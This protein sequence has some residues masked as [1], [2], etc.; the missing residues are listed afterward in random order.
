M[1]R[2]VPRVLRA[3]PAILCLA[4]GWWAFA[5]AP[6]G[7]HLQF[8]V[9]DGNSMEPKL[10][11]GDVVALRRVHSARP[12]EVVAYR[13]DLLER[14]VLHR[15]VGMSDGRYLMQGDNNGWTDPERPTDAQL[16]GRR[17]FAVHGLGRLF[18]PL[19]HPTVAALLI[20]LLAFAAVGSNGGRRPRERATG[21]RRIVPRAERTA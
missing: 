8:V 18:R 14:V 15:V 3:L 4:A 21:R 19:E 7:Q 10:H 9:P 6:G 16:I 2:P 17:V 13:S 11:E 1:R 20:A 5:P 12:G